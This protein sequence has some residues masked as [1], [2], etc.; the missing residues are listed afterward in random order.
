MSYPTDTAYER[1]LVY[2]NYPHVLAKYSVHHILDL[3]GH[4]PLEDGG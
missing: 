2:C 3:L 1:T 4:G